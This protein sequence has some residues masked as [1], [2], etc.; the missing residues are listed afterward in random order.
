V[1]DA[2]RDDADLTGL[3]YADALRELEAI[4]AQLEGDA[5]DVDVLATRVRRAA[6]LVRLCRGRIAT[7]RM[8][9]EQV[10]SQLEDGE[11]PPPSD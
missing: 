2:P 5:V 10:V 8:E 7:A 11:P 1:S 9:V 4:L 6:A 3:G